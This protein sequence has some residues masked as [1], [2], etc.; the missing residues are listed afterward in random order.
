[1]VIICETRLRSQ[2]LQ[3]ELAIIKRSKQNAQKHSPQVI[4]LE[5]S[6]NEE[7]TQSAETCM[8]LSLNRCESIKDSSYIG[9]ITI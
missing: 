8:L 1:M 3:K 6:G 4:E 9:Y 7:E 5:E 2:L